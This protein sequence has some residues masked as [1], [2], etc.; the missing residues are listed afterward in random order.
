VRKFAD[1]LE[2]LPPEGL[3]LGQRAQFGGVCDAARWTRVCKSW[4]RA[5]VLPV[6]DVA[7]AHPPFIGRGV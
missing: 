1:Q 2:A 6:C 3:K 7:D 5:W 4:E